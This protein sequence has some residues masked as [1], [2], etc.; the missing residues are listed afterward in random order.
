MR[1]HNLDGFRPGSLKRLGRL[2]PDGEYVAVDFEWVVRRRGGGINRIEMKESCNASVRG[3]D[4]L[5][6]LGA[7]A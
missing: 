3:P 7:C 1:R 6:R 2:V 4:L 5:Q